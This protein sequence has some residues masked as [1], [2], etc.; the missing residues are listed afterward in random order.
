V[1]R[2]A[3]RVHRQSRTSIHILV[4]THIFMF[5]Y[6]MHL[7]QSLLRYL[8][9][10]IDLPRPGRPPSALL[11]VAL[12][13]CGLW[14]SVCGTLCCACACV[15]RRQALEHGESLCLRAAYVWRRGLSCLVCSLYE[16]D[17]MQLLSCS[18]ASRSPKRRSEPTSSA[19]P[20]CMLLSTHM[21]DDNDDDDDA[22]YY[23][24]HWPLGKAAQLYPYRRRMLVI[25]RRV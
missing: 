24:R 14:L 23:W 20:L 8:L 17:D 2:T 3:A 9:Q 18:A 22:R 4:N 16:I 10:C 1:T 6:T 13:E 25:G 21:Y 12:R 11:P 5:T 15:G 7:L 19:R